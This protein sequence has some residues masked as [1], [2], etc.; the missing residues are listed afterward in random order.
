MPRQFLEIG[1]WWSTK[2]RL[3]KSRPRNGEVVEPP[4]ASPRIL[5]RPPESHLLVLGVFSSKCVSMGTN[6]FGL[7]GP[8]R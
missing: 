7:D 8:P 6:L 4:G 1:G 5:I 3:I 2:M